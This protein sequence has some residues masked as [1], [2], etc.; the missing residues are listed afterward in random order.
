MSFPPSLKNHI[1]QYAS[2]T[3]E[4]KIIGELN[5]FQGELMLIPTAR[6]MATPRIIT[7]ILNYVTLI[8]PEL[9]LLSLQRPS[10]MLKIRQYIKPSSHRFLKTD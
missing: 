7:R 2:Y 1:M 6:L 4:K 9:S 5:D 3:R 8:R 10:Y